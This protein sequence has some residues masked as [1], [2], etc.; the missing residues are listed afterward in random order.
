MREL[1]KEEKEFR[2]DVR[3]QGSFERLKKMMTTAPVVQFFS[4]SKKLVIQCDAS[5][6]GL[7]MAILQDGKILE[8]ASRV[9]TDTKK[10]YAQNER[11]C[12]PLSILFERWNTYT[13]ERHVTVETDHNPLFVINKKALAAASKLLQ[14]M[15]LR[16]QRYDSEL[17]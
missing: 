16:L 15:L 2:C 4:P 10:M 12:W 17:V 11:S 7:V 14:R 8:Y 1:L 3:H 13:Y 9:M 6:S 5:Q